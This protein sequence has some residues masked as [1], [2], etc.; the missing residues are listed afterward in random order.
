VAKEE[1]VKG[2]GGG[3]VAE[4]PATPGIIMSAKTNKLATRAKPGN[5]DN[6]RIPC[7]MADPFS[8]TTFYK[9]W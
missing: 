7:V 8:S 4:T 3:F 1:P 9:L 2:G 6:F 5:R